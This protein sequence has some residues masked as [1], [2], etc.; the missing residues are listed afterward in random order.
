VIIFK[1][2]AL[3]VT[4]PMAGIKYCLD[5]VVEFADHELNDEEPIKHELLE[6][7]LA[8]EEGRI[9]EDEYREREAPLVARLREVRE[10][11]RE[12]ARQSLESSAPADGEERTVV[13]ELP[14]ELK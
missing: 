4:A 13:I 2:L 3:P 5:K 14:E 7:A 10:Y 1:L 6:L 8:L 11:A 9:S 12:R